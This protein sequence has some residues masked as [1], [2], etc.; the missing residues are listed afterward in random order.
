MAGDS[1]RRSDGPKAHARKFRSPSAQI[2]ALRICQHRRVTTNAPIAPSHNIASSSVAQSEL[3]PLPHNS[4]TPITGGMNAL[5]SPCRFVPSG[6]SVVISRPWPARTQGPVVHVDQ[7]VVGHTGE[8][9]LQPG[10]PPLCAALL[11]AAHRRADTHLRDRQVSPGGERPGRVR[12]PE[13]RAHRPLQ[14]QPLYGGPHPPDRVTGELT[15]HD[16]RD[17]YLT[18]GLPEVAHSAA[19]ANA[20]IG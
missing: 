1:V 16:L 14:G 17:R 3:A 10:D 19:S 9:A 13:L 8:L 6:A 5:S 15:L 11:R 4:V 20:L 12:H 7:R 2:A 18:P